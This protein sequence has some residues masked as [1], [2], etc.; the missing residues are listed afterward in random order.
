[1]PWSR[2]LLVAA[3]A[4]SNFPPWFSHTIRYYIAKENY[5]HHRFKKKPSD[6]LYYRFA[7]YRKLVKGTIKSDR[8]RWLKS[9]AKNLKLQPQHFW[10][11]IPNLRKHRSGSIQLNFDGAH[12]AEQVLMLSLV[13]TVVQSTFPVSRIL[14]NFYPLLLFLMRISTKP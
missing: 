9:I 2:Q 13:V 14:L 10:K 3:G 11:Y 7:L 6:C 1:M 4:K 5:F 8:L 12:L